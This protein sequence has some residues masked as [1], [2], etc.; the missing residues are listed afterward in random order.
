MNDSGL[1]VFMNIL[2]E[3]NSMSVKWMEDWETL[4][5]LNLK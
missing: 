3:R 4:W 2:A 1:Y 5:C